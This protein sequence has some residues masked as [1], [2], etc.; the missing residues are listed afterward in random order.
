MRRET[1]LMFA[2]VLGMEYCTAALPHSACGTRNP[3]L[4]TGSTRNSTRPPW[5]GPAVA[6]AR[7]TILYWL[8]KARPRSLGFSGPSGPL[9]RGPPPVPGQ[10]WSRKH[11]TW[12]RGKDQCRVQL[13]RSPAGGPS[14]EEAEG[15]AGCQRTCDR[16]MDCTWGRG[17]SKLLASTT[18]ISPRRQTKLS[19]FWL[20]GGRWKLTSKS[21]RREPHRFT[22]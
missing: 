13:S 3:S 20:P 14:P 21:P 16:E 11:R 19:S 6:T 10:Q 8:T 5:P 15:A 7:S 9:P 4:G 2:H 22:S 12:D 18:W 1:G 17:A